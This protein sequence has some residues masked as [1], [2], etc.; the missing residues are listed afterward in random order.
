MRVVC[1][2]F[3][4]IRKYSLPTAAF[5]SS[6][7]TKLTSQ[8]YSSSTTALNTMSKRVLVPIADGSEEIE[9]TCIT[10]TLTRFG[11][12]VTIASVMPEA[13]LLCTMSRG[14]KVM[15]DMSIDD[16]ANGDYDLVVCPGGMPGAEHLRDSKVL[17][18]IL[19]KQKEKGLK[20]AA[21][22][23]APAVTLASHNLIGE[24]ATC[25]PAPHFR[26]QLVDPVDDSVAVSEDGLV[27]T[28]KGPGTA[29]DFA[30]ELGEQLFGKEARE[31]IQK[32]MLL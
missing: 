17:I 7:T 21:I 1:I 32:E 13:Q 4:A 26:A 31:K 20:Y 14:M 12:D 3:L 16:A 30:L 27:T 10:D 28:S 22:C 24:K 25:Y 11:A 18:S 2:V 9:T 8:L 5:S 19:K 23:A 15:A 29:L 6:T